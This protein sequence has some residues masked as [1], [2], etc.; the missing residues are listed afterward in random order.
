MLFPRLLFFTL[1]TSTVWAALPARF[2]A[3]RGQSP[4]AVQFQARGDGQSIFLTSRGATFHLSDP[5]SPSTIQLQFDN[6]GETQLEGDGLLPGTANYFRGND[7]K[8]WITNIPTYSRVRY[9]N[10]YP[11]IDLVFYTSAGN[12][13]FDWVLAP[14]ADPKQI[15]FSLKGAKSTRLEEIGRA[16]V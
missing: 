14:Q 4:E 11:G 13:E 12:V 9:R 1:L 8:Q 10:I 5:V 7:P 6:V 16:H 3:N 15:R 2:E